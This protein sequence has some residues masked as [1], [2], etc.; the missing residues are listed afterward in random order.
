MYPYVEDAVLYETP[1]GHRVFLA[2]HDK[3]MKINK[4]VETILSYC[5]GVTEEKGVVDLITREMESSPEEAWE[6]YRKISD[7]FSEKGVLKY[8]DT[9]HEHPLVYR[10]RILNPPF[11]MAY[12]ELTYRCNLQCMHCY[13]AAGDAKELDTQEWKNVIDVLFD[14]GCLRVFLTG[15]E[16]LLHEG[17]ID[18]LE[19]ARSKYMAVGVL[20]NGVLLD[21]ETA[22][23]MKRRGVTSLHFSV[24]GPAA[25]IHDEFRGVKG[26]FEK[27]RA[28]VQL[29][30]SKGLRVKVT[31][32]IHR[33]NLEE[34]E[35]LVNLMNTLGITE[36]NFVPVIKSFRKEENAVT[37]EEFVEFL[38][39]LP[40][41][42]RVTLYA[43]QYVKNCGIG[44]KECVIHPDGTVG[45]CTP[46]GAEGPV[47]GDLKTDKFTD[48]WNTPFLQ[49]LRTIDAFNHEKCG[50]CPHVKY[51]L[52][53]CMANT[54]YVTGDITCGSPYACARY[55]V[56]PCSIDVIETQETL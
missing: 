14:C 7:I 56:L 10:P 11:E 21:D 35:N 9:P 29:A 53:G 31:T 45:L 18:I 50:N 44:Y 6:S 1:L 15:G 38:K 55:S 34:G 24:D 33:K 48:I 12:L 23:R 54:F 3:K 39:T 49:E 20:T 42:E 26:S 16:P 52:G 13:N 30:L 19:H 25:F 43:P 4:N 17:F 22:E 41:K 27:T 47:L 5:N 46:F 36:Y 40:Q 28:A 32:C 8:S 37:P 51:C 2:T